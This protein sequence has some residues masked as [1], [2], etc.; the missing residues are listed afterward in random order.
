MEQRSNDA[1]VKDVQIDPSEE[2]CVISMGLKSK[3]DGC[4][5]K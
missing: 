1:A 5:I 2:E 3:Y 4:K